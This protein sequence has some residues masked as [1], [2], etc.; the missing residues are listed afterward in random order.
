MAPKN[1]KK[2]QSIGIKPKMPESKIIQ[3]KSFPKKASDLI[4]LSDLLQI[5]P[6]VPSYIQKHK[7]A[8]NKREKNNNFSVLKNENHVLM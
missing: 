8:T 4:K 7:A 6:L 3:E 5:E 1:I 2:L